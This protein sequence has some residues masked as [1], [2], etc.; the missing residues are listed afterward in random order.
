MKQL[1]NFKRLIKKYGVSCELLSESASG[2][3][4]GGEWVPGVAAE[5]Q[6]IDGAVIPMSTK[7]I[8]Q[9]G[10]TYT[11][12]DREFITDTEIQLEPERYIVYKGARYKVQENTDYSDY[13]GFYAYNLKRVE[14]LE[15]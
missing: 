1:F 5:S 10:G 11:E 14:V 13:A 7:K 9:S 8:Y 15:Q 12:Q 2:S 4:V 3:Y 6:M